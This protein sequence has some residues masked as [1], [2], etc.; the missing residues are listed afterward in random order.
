MR[1]FGYLF[2]L[3]GVFAAISFAEEGSIAPESERE[4]ILPQDPGIPWLTTVTWGWGLSSDLSTWQGGGEILAPVWQDEDSLLYLNAW[5]GF[6]E[7]DQ[8]YFSVGGG[9]RTLNADKTLLLG[10]NAFWDHAEMDDLASIDRLGLGLE[11]STWILDLRVNGYLSESERAIADSLSVLSYGSLFAEEHSVFQPLTMAGVESLSGVEFEIGR[12]LP[13]PPE[14]PFSIGLWAGAYAFEGTVDDSVSLEGFRARAEVGLTDK[15][16]LDAAYYGDEELIGGNAYVGLRASIPF[17]PG[18]RKSAPGDD[19]IVESYLAAKLGQR[20][21]R[22]HRVTHTSTV[23]EKVEIADDL[24]FVNEGKA[25]SNGIESGSSDGDGTAEHPYATVQGGASQAARKNRDTGRIWNVYTQGGDF[26][27]REDVL[28]TDSVRFTSSAVPIVGMGGQT[29][30]TGDIPLIDGGFLSRQADTVGIEGYRVINGARSS[31]SGGLGNDRGRG[32]GIYFEG[33]TDFTLTNTTIEE[34]L[35]SG[36]V[37]VGKS[38]RNSTLEIEDTK[39]RNNG[40]DGIAIVGRAGWVGNGEITGNEIAGNRGDG[41][42]VELAN[43]RFGGEI[44]DNESNRN[45][46]NGFRFAAES[47]GVLDLEILD[48]EAKNNREDG[49]HLEYPN[50]AVYATVERN[51]ATS[52]L[53]DGFEF[54]NDNGIFIGVVDANVA[55]TNG[56]SGFRFDLAT[57]RRLEAEISGN[58]AVG[59]LGNGFQFAIPT[60]GLFGDIFNNRAFANGGFGLLIDASNARIDGNIHENIASENLLDGI[61]VRLSGA[62]I[63]GEIARNVSTLNIGDGFDINLNNGR[64]VGRIHNNYAAYNHGNGFKITSGQGVVTQ[65]IVQNIADRNDDSGFLLIYDVFDTFFGANE[66]IKN[67]GS[68]FRVKTFDDFGENGLFI[69]N[70][71]NDN[72]YHGFDFRLDDDHSGLIANNVSKGSGLAGFH[73]TSGDDFQDDGVFRDNLAHGNGGGGF[74]LLVAEDFEGVFM[75]NTARANEGG[76]IDIRIG[77]DFIDNPTAGSALITHNVATG[78]IGNGISVTIGED[79]FADAQFKFNVATGNTGDGINIFV[80]DDSDSPPGAFPEI[81]NNTAN[82][83]G[84]NGIV[85]E[86]TDGFDGGEFVSNTA[87]GNGA[88]G[89][90]F[91]LDPNDLNGTDGAQFEDS[92]RFSGNTTNLNGGFGI[93]SDVDEDGVL[94]DGGNTQT[95]NTAGAR[96]VLGL[97]DLGDNSDP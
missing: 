21:V 40:G 38:G 34:T 75:S 82:G 57:G 90:V 52:N 64:I 87:N 72:R 67:S 6:Y 71:A 53:G 25:L 66:A 49:F 42:T 56:V 4:A 32:N 46:E 12:Q 85:F 88:N 7:R 60:G 96:S 58:L 10:V 74:F 94:T 9:F 22:H 89:I 48:N 28:V 68:G 51:T 27:Y 41:L 43:A 36:V 31:L 20:V 54:K 69:A 81:S 76:G 24:V 73:L 47:G 97:D 18:S 91:L 13:L 35:D 15:L 95:G 2:F 1:I 3:F 5:T 79:L 65:G 78:N 93:V 14:F 33:V 16:F 92:A 26:D 44:S 11:I 62:V 86:G 8:H 77:R 29:F 39:V 61:K 23:T 83:N 17:G 80:G 84:G 19:S 45:S 59:N 55:I 70:V 63:T 37:F 30:G 50:A